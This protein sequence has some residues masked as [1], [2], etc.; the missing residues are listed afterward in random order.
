MQLSPGSWSILALAALSSIALLFAPISHNTGETF[1]TFSLDLD[2]MYRPIVVDWNKAHPDP[3]EQVRTYVIGTTSLTR[4]LQSGFLSG[5]PVPDLSE[6]ESSMAGNFFS[7]PLDAVGFTDLTDI[8]HKEGLDTKIN[9][10]SFGPWTNRGRIFGL[11]HDVHPVLLAY[12]ADIVEAAG[13]D[14]SKIETWDDFIRVMSP[15][16][17]GPDG[18]RFLINIWET[19]PQAME[20]LI[21]QAGGGFFDQNLQP[22]LNSDTNARVLST[23]VSWIAG[24]KR[25]CVNAPDFD[26]EGNY[27]FLHGD[28]LCTLMPDWLGGIW[29]KDLSGLSGKM[30]VMPIP[31]WEKGGLR[32]SVFGG[33]ML[34][35][36][37]RAPDFQRSWE[38]AKHLYLSPELAKELYLKVNI[39]TPVRS[40]WNDP[41]YD[42]PNPYFSG[43]ASG[44]LYV[45]MASQ[46][47]R[48]TSS[49]YKPQ[50]VVAIN[51][52]LIRLKQYAVRENTYDAPALMAQARV[53]LNTAQ[54]EIKRKM[55]AN[56]FLQT[57]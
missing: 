35:I 12:R 57:P 32:T 56:A 51:D 44:R 5:T 26:A 43:Q 49:P 17:K 39:I 54:A 16:M 33:T 34:G 20:I 28:V 8:I 11:P 18:Q 30:K 31:A 13:I 29:M 45:Q 24:P 41:V 46:V 37:K 25:V 47:P 2:S 4:R 27:L 42:Q 9:P 3:E 21:L 36:P 52:A 22:I 55:A 7:G 40:F 19:N 23:I 10:A 14:V 38:F 50:A 1:W 53:E 6:V 48:R 15:L